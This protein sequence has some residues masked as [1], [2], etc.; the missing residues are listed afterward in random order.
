MVQGVGG[1]HPGT[2]WRPVYTHVDPDRQIEFLRELEQRVE[3]GVVQHRPVRADP[4]D[5]H[6]GEVL[7]LLSPVPQLRGGVRN[8]PHSR[9]ANPR[10]SAVRLRT[11][12]ADKPVVGS[13]QRALEPNVVERTETIRAARKDNADID[14]RSVH[15]PESDCRIPVAGG[16]DFDS[17]IRDLPAVEIA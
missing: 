16:I 9:A 4:R 17:L 8:V 1:L 11:I 13:V 14:S 7:I 5:E 3:V 6:S 12:V 2:V 15:V 10:Q